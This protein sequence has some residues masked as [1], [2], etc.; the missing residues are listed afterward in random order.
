MDTVVDDAVQVAVVVAVPVV[1]NMSTVEVA[2]I[3]MSV[4]VV[5]ETSDQRGSGRSD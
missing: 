5:M 2:P 3:A 4:G 1:G